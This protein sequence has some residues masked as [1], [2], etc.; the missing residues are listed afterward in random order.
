MRV[1]YIAGLYHIVLLVRASLLPTFV[2][3]NGSQQREVSHMSP[4]TALVIVSA[5]SGAAIGAFTLLVIG[6]RKGDRGLKIAPRTQ[7]T[8]LPGAALPA[9]ES[10]TGRHDK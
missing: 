3:T 9:S 1:R 2:N 8:Q 10:T 7:V 6:I 5:L 4:F